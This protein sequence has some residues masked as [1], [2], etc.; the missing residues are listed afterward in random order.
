MSDLQRHQSCVNFLDLIRILNCIAPGDGDF[1]FCRHSR[2]NTHAGVARKLIEHCLL[3]LIVFSFVIQTRWA[4]SWLSNSLYVSLALSVLYPGL[5]H[6]D[7][8][9]LPV[10]VTTV[11]RQELKGNSPPVTQTEMRSLF[12]S[13]LGWLEPLSDI[14][15]C[16][17]PCC[18]VS[19]I[20]CLVIHCSLDRK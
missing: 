20:C 1:R 11:Y 16:L 4:W 18:R 3:C 17:C 14:Y 9:S 7:F 8:H 19:F 10:L 5:Q 12:F 13:T 15:F 6:T 2:M